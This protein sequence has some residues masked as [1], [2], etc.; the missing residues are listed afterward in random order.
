MLYPQELAH[1]WNHL[2]DH[3][4]PIK[5]RVEVFHK[6]IKDRQPKLAIG[7]PL[8]GY[9]LAAYDYT[10]YPLYKGEVY[11]EAKV[12]FDIDEKMG[13]VSKN[14]D[15]YYAMCDVL[16]DYFQADHPDL[17]MLDIQDF[18]FCSE[19]YDKVRVE[20][21]VDYLFDLASTLA[22]FRDDTQ[23]FINEIIDLGETTLQELYQMYEGGEKVRGIRFRVID[24]MIKDGS[25]TVDQ[26]E[27]VK[28]VVSHQYDTNILRS[29]NNFTTLF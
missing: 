11:Q 5:E 2:Y 7:A 17:T 26:L 13:S 14:Y 27:Q 9:L 19:H 12:N 18:L 8:F 23:F 21:A 4:V 29:Y 10:M 16:L 1:V 20:T 3:T 6:T 15:I 22:S 25:F 24:H 28:E